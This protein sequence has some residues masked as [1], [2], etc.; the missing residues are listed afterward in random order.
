MTAP[1][2]LVVDDEK[3]MC[4]LLSDVLAAE[5]YAVETCGNG[6]AAIKAGTRRAWN[7]IILDLHLPDMDGRDVLKALREHRV[8]APVIIITAHGT[9]DA[10]V[11]A[12]RQGAFDFIVKPFDIERV[13][14]GVAKA[15]EAVGLISAATRSCPTFARSVLA[16][17]HIVGESH[18]LAEVMEIVAKVAHSNA[19]V[20]IQGESGTGKE[21]VAQ[22][23]HYNGARKDEAL[24]PINCAALPETLL[25]SEL[26][27][28][29]RGSFTGAYS[30]KI[31]KF[32]MA[33][34]GTL[35]LDEVGDMSLA[36]QAKLLRVLETK[37]FS[38]VGGTEPIQVDVRVIAA[39]NKYLEKAV[40]EERF[41][42]DLYYRLNVIPISLP[43]LR[44]RKEDIRALGE[45][46]ID[47][48]C[49]ENGLEE[50]RF[51]D[52]T[53][54]RLEEYDW[55]GNIR[56]LQNVVEKGVVLGEAYAWPQ[57]APVPRPGAALAPA[58]ESGEV[59]SLRRVTESAQREAIIRAIRKTAGNKSEAAKLL[60][61]GYKTLFNKINELGIEFST[62][63]E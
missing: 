24:V 18:K 51:S 57:G 26:F 12:M 11:Q 43:P 5:G 13:K 25:E 33:D 60:G 44:E 52:E 58:P 14:A 45:H 20:L 10:A 56:E 16:E 36:M 59:A 62:T 9:I 31:G 1:R 29:E 7:A 35:F 47:K 53:M 50:V 19:T 32:E 39:T 41:R 4:E 30:R 22:A 15:Q 2:I 61:I 49:S 63:V 54:R 23:I 40:A 48:Y 6:A 37:A 21:L 27:G 38:R 17:Q 55:P 8:T 3:N 34:G 42:E 46:F 28:F